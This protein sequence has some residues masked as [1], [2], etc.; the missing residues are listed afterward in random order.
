MRFYR[1]DAL[2]QNERFLRIGANFNVWWKSENKTEDL[3]PRTK[4]H[5]AE[6]EAEAEAEED[7]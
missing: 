3:K 2:S 5:V 7:A 4:Y 6:N 1:Q